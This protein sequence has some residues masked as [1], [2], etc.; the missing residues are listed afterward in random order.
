MNLTPHQQRA[1]YEYDK[2][3]IVIAGAGSG[4]TRVLVERYLHL[5][6]THPEWPLNALVA[7]TFTRKAAQEM[8]DRVRQTLEERLRHAQAGEEVRIWSS[9]LASMDSARIDTIHGLCATILRANAAEAGLD[10]RFDVLDEIDAAMLLDD[11][12][13]TALQA[14]AEEGD[15]IAQLF[16]EYDSRSLRAAL[17][18]FANGDIPELPSNLFGQWQAEWEAEA[19]EH[20]RVLRADPDFIEWVEWLPVDGWPI[21]DDK[22]R[23]IWGQFIN[24][25]NILLES[26][27]LY[28]CL[29]ALEQM[30]STKIAGNVG[31]AAAWG[32]KEAADRARRHANTLKWYAGNTLE[33]IGSPPG[34]LE[35]RAAHLLPLWCRLVERVQTTYRQ[36]KQDRLDFDDLERLTRDLLLAHDGVRSRYQNAEFKHVLVD[37][38]QD[39]NSVQWEIV[40]SLAHVSTPGSLF[41]VGDQKQ[42]IYAFRGADVSV[43]GAVRATLTEIWGSEAEIPLSR[44]FRTHAPLV[45][46]FNT[47]FQHILTRDPKSMAYDYEIDL[48]APMDAFRA[49]PPAESPVFE[50]LLVNPPADEKISPDDK[51]RWE[52]YE[53]AQRI[54]Q[55]VGTPVYDKEAGEIRAM[56]YDDVALLFQATSNINLY[57]DVFKAQNLPFVTVAGRGYYNRQEVWDLLNLLNA[58]YNPV[59]N[60][61]LA[62]VLRSPMFGLSDDALLALRLILD[63]STRKPILLWDALAQPAP[64]MP[65]DEL[66]LVAF[67]RDCLY[68]LHMLAG[69]VTISELLREALAQTG[70]LATLTGLPDGVRRRGN[71]EKLIDK[72]ESS[73]KVTL[74]AFSQY[75]SDLSAREVREGEA[76]LDVEGAVTLM[77]VH[78]SKGLE[79]PVVVLVDSGWERTYRGTTAL[80]RDG[81]GGLA[82]KVYD[83]EAEKL[84]GTFSYVRAERVRQLRETAER[85]RLLYVAATRAQDYLIVS[86]CAERDKNGELKQDV[87]LRWLLEALELN[88]TTDQPG[89]LERDWGRLRLHVARQ[90]PSEDAYIIGDRDQTTMWEHPAVRVGQPLPGDGSKPL[91]MNDVPKNPT[92]PARHLSVTQLADLGGAHN[93]YYRLRFRRSVLHDA[94]AAIQPATPYRIHKQLV[95]EIVHEALRWWRFPGEIE[96]LDKLLDSYAWEKGILDSNQREQAVQDAY[97]LLIKF[98][99]EEN[100][101][102]QWVCNARQ[103]YR[104]VPFVYRKGEH[105]IHGVIDTLFEHED[106]TWVIIDYKTAFVPNYALGQVALAEHARRFYLQVGAYAEAVREQMRSVDGLKLRVYIHYIRYSSTVE[107]GEAE[108]QAALASLEKLVGLSLT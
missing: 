26:T 82:C 60:L 16:A 39:T 8:R 29:D 54:H 86:G 53:I 69:R 83:P 41:V 74:G 65:N 1:I 57:E 106:G 23:D 2:N 44:S 94:P 30:S 17:M 45:N 14:L 50:L 12:I 75:L 84:V 72:A 27:N 33:K 103:L 88:E 52:A 91:L 95:G 85:K 3:L 90:Q 104:E 76:A 36:A 92:A 77:T 31:T 105:I 7:I 64:Y 11:V 99:S 55:L 35:E 80:V 32:S 79:F 68:S 58:L 25:G 13:D 108:W 89:V 62:S 107:I 19:I 4:K 81:R 40:Q 78:A 9:R 37:E 56:R 93:P 66:E 61:A 63:E 42:S 59:D 71:V 100:K 43:F 20:L 46:C 73:G 96:N 87:W 51:R 102:Y 6:D 15:E 97:K 67:A 49:E 101:L 24:W 38:F 10:P 47:L 22:L 28:D 5:L 70:Y 18:E 21:I 98:K 34:A 48:G